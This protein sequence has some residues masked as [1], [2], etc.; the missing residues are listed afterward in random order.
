M[1]FVIG[2]GMHLRVML[3]KNTMRSV[4]TTEYSTLYQTNQTLLR[5]DENK[6]RKQKSHQSL[7]QSSL[8]PSTQSYVMTK[9]PTCLHVPSTWPLHHLMSVQHFFRIV[10][11][12]FSFLCIVFIFLLNTN[13]L[14]NTFLFFLLNTS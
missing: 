10:C 13:N 7:A 5:F 6:T 11:L 2:S 12:F 14:S 4:T 8:N 1:Q 9:F 3:L